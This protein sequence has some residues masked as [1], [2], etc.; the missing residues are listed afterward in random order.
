MSRSFFWFV[1]VGG[2]GF[3]VDAGM[4]MVIGYVGVSYIAARVPAIVLAMMTTWL[5]NR[6]FTFSVRRKKSVS[7]AARYATVSI[8]SAIL[9]FLLYSWLVKHG[10]WPPVAVAIATGCLMVF[11]FFGYRTLAFGQHGLN[12]ANQS[13]Q[14]AYTE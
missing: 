2:V 6:R 14:T 5:L 13:K 10:V 1:F 12:D 7:E 9:N 4:T 11:S 3:I 8:V